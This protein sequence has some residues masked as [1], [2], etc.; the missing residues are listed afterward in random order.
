MKPALSVDLPSACSSM[1]Q[2][3]VSGSSQLYFCGYLSFVSCFLDSRVWIKQLSL[4]VLWDLFNRIYHTFILD[5]TPVSTTVNQL[6]QSG[7]MKCV[8]FIMHLFQLYLYG[9]T[10]YLSICLYIGI[11]TAC[12]WI[13]QLFVYMG[14]PPVFFYFV[15]IYAGRNWVNCVWQFQVSIWVYQ[16]FTLDL[17]YD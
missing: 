12:I 10:V 6:C 3:F 11:S 5:R 13:I 15:L 4:C 1:C 17:P 14:L 2:L 9:S 16:L 8:S 7:Y